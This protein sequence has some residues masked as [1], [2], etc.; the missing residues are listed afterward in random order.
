M[1][2]IEP[3]YLFPRDVPMYSRYMQVSQV[4]PLRFG[5]ETLVK[6]KVQSQQPR[7]GEGEDRL[8]G[9]FECASV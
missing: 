2:R 4:M 8:G 6:E 3:L 9:R 7:D 1:D 5:N